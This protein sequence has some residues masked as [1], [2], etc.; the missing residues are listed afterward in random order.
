M[1]FIPPTIE[2]ATRPMA[3]MVIG[4]ANCC[5]VETRCIASLLSDYYLLEHGCFDRLST[6]NM[7]LTDK[8]GLYLSVKIR[9]I[10]L[11]RVL[12]IKHPKSNI[13]HLTSKLAPTR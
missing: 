13:L 12:K 9:Q 10:R 8:H 1:F 11:I 6:R 2:S 7:D 3:S 4:V 5:C